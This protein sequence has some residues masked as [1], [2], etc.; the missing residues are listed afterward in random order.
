MKYLP[1]KSGILPLLCLGILFG[2]FAFS[3]PVK[4]K[5]LQ[6]T[7]DDASTLSIEGSSSV[8]SFNCGCEEDFKQYCCSLNEQDNSS[9]IHFVNTELEVKARSFDCGGKVINRDMQSALK[10]K[11]HPNI[12]IALQE[13]V[14]AKPGLFQ[15]VCDEWITLKA[16]TEITIA[17]TSQLVELNIRAKELQ[18]KQYR[19]MGSKELLMTDFGIEPPRP[20]M[21][22]IKVHDEITINLDFV[23]TVLGEL[24]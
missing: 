4:T 17:G 6:F 9:T 5:T 24:Q 14:L 10:S 1:S 8:N 11:K 21:G 19:F 13:V 15:R 20:M 22:L 18:S 2:W 7:I 16:K 3:F 23:V 12:K